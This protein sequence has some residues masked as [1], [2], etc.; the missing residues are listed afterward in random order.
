[1]LAGYI[2]DRVSFAIRRLRPFHLWGEA[3]QKVGLAV[4]KIPE[5]LTLSVRGT[6]VSAECQRRHA[7]IVSL[8]A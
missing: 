6:R 4:G 2:D 1:M 8:T 7:S 5:G 3:G